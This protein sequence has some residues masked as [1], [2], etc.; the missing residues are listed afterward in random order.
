MKDFREVLNGNY[1][2][3]YLTPERHRLKYG[4]PSKILEQLLID[5]EDGSCQ[6]V[7][8]RRGWFK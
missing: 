1:D 8:T 2:K 5:I 3:M 4:T 6:D 7:E